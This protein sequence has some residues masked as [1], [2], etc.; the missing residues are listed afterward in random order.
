[1]SFKKDVM[2][3]LTEIS[4]KIDEIQKKL[5]AMSDASLLKEYYAEMDKKLS[6]LPDEMAR[7]LE[8]QVEKLRDDLKAVSDAVSQRSES[9][10]AVEKKTQKAKEKSSK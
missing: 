10:P 4:S 6:D 5:E 3:K 2:D 9:S 7:M 1:M 8:A